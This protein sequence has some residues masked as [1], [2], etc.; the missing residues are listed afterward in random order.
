M[1]YSKSVA[2]SSGTPVIIKEHGMTNC[3]AHV[4]QT[5]AECEVA[6]SIANNQNY[7]VAEIIT[8]DAIVLEAPGITAI[9]LTVTAG[10]ANVTV[11]GG[12]G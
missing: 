10:T 8:D 1:I 3:S 4:I 2:V 6:Y 12:Q 5:D 11:S 9:R 7:A